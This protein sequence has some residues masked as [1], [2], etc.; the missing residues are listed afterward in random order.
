MP[1]MNT[2]IFLFFK[3]DFFSYF[4]NTF[5][6]DRPYGQTQKFKNKSPL[7]LEKKRNFGQSNFW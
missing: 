1:L 4:Q 7:S 5:T 6:Q 2:H 3:N